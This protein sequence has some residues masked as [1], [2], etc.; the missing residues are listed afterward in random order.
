MAIRLR[1]AFLLLAFALG[2]PPSVHAQQGWTGSLETLSAPEAFISSNGPNARVAIDPAGNAIAVWSRYSRI[3]AARSPATTHVW[4]MP[5]DLGRGEYPQIVFDT[6]SNAFVVWRE[7]G[8]IHAARYVAATAQWHAAVAIGDSA[9]YEAPVVVTSGPDVVVLWVGSGGLYSARFAAS[10]V[11]WQPQT[12]VATTWS[13]PP[14][15][16]VDHM[17]NITAMFEDLRVSN[18]HGISAVRYLRAD[19]SWG[20]VTALSTVTGSVSSGPIA[21]DASGNVIAVWNVLQ[22]GAHGV[23]QA[24]R[25]VAATNTWTPPTTLPGSQTVSTPM[26]GVDA[27]GNA[28]VLWDGSGEQ[29]AHTAR[30]VVETDQWSDGGALPM[31]EGTLIMSAAVDSNG[32]MTVMIA[33]GAVHLYR[34]AVASPEWTAPTVVGAHTWY[35]APLA[36]DASGNVLASWHVPF[37]CPDGHGALIPPECGIVSAVRWSSSLGTWGGVT[38]VSE[39]VRPSIAMNAAGNAAAV[40]TWWRP[41]DP[42]ASVE[43][44][45]HLYHGEYLVQGTHWLATPAAPHIE[46]VTPLDGGLSV[47]FTAPVT[48]EPQFEPTTYEYLACQGSAWLARQP[49]SVQSPLVIS[50]SSGLR[51]SVQVRAVNS[52]GAGAASNS[53]ANTAGP[54]PAPPTDLAVTRIDGFR[55]T[56]AWTA[57]ADG[58]PISG[59]V[60]EGGTRPGEVAASIPVSA[61]QT[62]LTFDSPVDTFY[63][64]VHSLAGASRSLASAEIH[65]YLATP[66]PPMGLCGGAKGNLVLLS[67]DA[68]PNSVRPTHYLVEAGLAPGATHAILATPDSRPRLRVLA[69]DGVFFVRVRAVAGTLVSAPSN[70]IRLEVTPLAPFAP[71]S[72]LGLVNDST[73]TL[74]WTLSG[75]G[76]PPTALRLAVTGSIETTVVLPVSES[77]SVAAVPPGTYTFTVSA[78]NAAGESSSSNAVTLSVPGA[79]SGAPQPPTEV[80][81]SVTDRVVE[82]GWTPPAAGT[83]VSGYGIVVSGSYTGVSTTTERGLTAVVAPGTYFVSL[84]SLN[85]CGA[86]APTQPVM[87]AVP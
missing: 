37:R 79:C 10:E 50:L 61:A 38:E 47:A 81:A 29:G 5:I 57:P 68:A 54:A 73:V 21:V 11:A 51:C 22:D 64:R 20:P 34:A 76:G 87:V 17:G 74:S 52:A 84:I 55:V 12:M 83:A 62:Q 82:L 2:T 14:R 42:T 8:S 40:W 60:V 85:A 25:F 41:N 48:T 46:S 23:V 1:R 72:L 24:A 43:E 58:V 70:E 36:I 16:T 32:V 63:L 27:A 69:P 30:Y 13:R 65:V 15:A 3:E 67:W 77:F 18:G 53:V 80:M 59:Y 4:E 35:L 33:A 56:V 45:L 66:G 6:A 7:V 39:G 44:P 31:S 19:L 26:L 78:L 71:Q 75:S 86:S 9:L 28:V 49:P